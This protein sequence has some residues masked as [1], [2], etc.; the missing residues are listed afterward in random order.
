MKKWY[1]LGFFLA[2]TALAHA[3]E[4][5]FRLDTVS[6]VG[7]DNKPM[8]NPWTGGLNGC[9]FS[10]MRLNNDSTDDLVVF[11]RSAGRVLTFVADQKRWKH[12]PEYEALFPDDLANW[13]LLVDYDRDGR[14]DLFTYA[15]QGL[16]VF[17]NVADGTRFRWQLSQDNVRTEGFSG[18]VNLLVA[19]S[20]IPA[21][22][23]LDDDGDVDVL[24]FDQSGNFVEF[25]KN[26]AIEQ[27][28]RNDTFAF[29]RMGL[30]WGNFIKEHCNDF[31]FGFDC[32]GGIN[33]RAARQEATARIQHAGNAILVQDFNN[34]GRKDL[35]FG[36][37]SCNNIAF[38]KNAAGNNNANITAFEANFPVKNPID[39]V[40]FPAAFLEDVDFDGVKDLLVSPNTSGNEKNDMNLQKSIWL[41]KNAGSDKAS[42]FDL[43]QKDFLQN[44]TIDVGENAAPALADYDGDGDL[45]LFVGNQSL[46]GALGLRANVGLYQNTGTPTRP[47][48]EWR[49]DDFLGLSEKNQLFNIKPF[50]ADINSD[51]T[52][53]YGW[54]ASSFKGMEIKYIPNRG[55]RGRAFEVTL[56]DT[57]QLQRPAR[58]ANGENVLFYDVDTDGKTDLL[59]GKNFGSVEYYRN[60]TGGNRPKYE[61]QN[62]TFAG[63]DVDFNNRSPAML[64]A[65]L[66][67]DQKNEFIVGNGEGTLRVFKNFSAQNVPQKTDSS[68]IFNDLE[69]KFRPARLGKALQIAVGD[70]DGD[71]LPDLVVGTNAGGLRLLKNVA[72]NKNQSPSTAQTALVYPNPADRFV[73]VRA[74]FGGF[75]EVFGTTGQRVTLATA[76]EA[77]VETALDLTSVPLGIYFVRLTD[78]LGRATTHKVLV[79]R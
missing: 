52:L 70:L 25:H 49:T 42:D 23:D 55:A 61:L 11:D 76:F 4:F 64:V 9:Q 8:L 67:S 57:I 36:H 77:N 58:M 2:I 5:G 72:I 47:R 27:T 50:F 68:L 37:I 32:S 40:V 35:L 48:F 66:N 74:P 44:Q 71:Q 3:Q 51:G 78:G 30:C 54:V 45:D 34:D 65:D 19:A 28:G 53:D 33:G 20:D 17:K 22:T 39:M 62:E 31:K 16:R 38:L 7:P 29:K 26:L 59:L 24:T 43:K 14:K 46:R 1:F 63:F 75:A 79:F 15:V 13:M 60:T 18:S 10:T 41:Y 73:Y 69:Q 56:A 12:A 6:V 21:I